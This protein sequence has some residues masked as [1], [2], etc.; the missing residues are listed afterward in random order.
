MGSGVSTID[1]E[2]QLDASAEND[3]FMDELEEKDEAAE[4]LFDPNRMF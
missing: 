3:E 4:W 1:D 2:S